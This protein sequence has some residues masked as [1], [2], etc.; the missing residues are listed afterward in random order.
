[1]NAVIGVTTVRFDNVL[2]YSTAL[3]LAWIF[4]WVRFKFKT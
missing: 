2:R 1:V 3:R 4:D